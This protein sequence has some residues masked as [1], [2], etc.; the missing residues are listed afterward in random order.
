M[1]LLPLV[2]MLKYIDISYSSIITKGYFKN[3]KSLSEK[4]S[5]NILRFTENPKY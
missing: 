1:L 5:L 3:Y 4:L 2:D